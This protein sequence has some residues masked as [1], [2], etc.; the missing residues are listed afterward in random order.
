M[1]KFFKSKKVKALIGTI[2]IDL[3]IYLAGP[4]WQDAAIQIF[5]LLGGTYIF[6]QSLADGIS[7]G[8][9]ASS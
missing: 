6:G 5:S 3:V 4:Q 9:T 1:K 8:K 7:G 2:I